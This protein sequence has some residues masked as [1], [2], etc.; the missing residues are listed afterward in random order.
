MRPPCSAC[1]FERA[2]GVIVSTHSD[3][4]KTAPPSPAQRRRPHGHK[5]TVDPTTP[6]TSTQRSDRWGDI[7]GDLTQ[8]SDRCSQSSFGDQTTVGALWWAPR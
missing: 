1:L 6:T 7:T 4:P 8:R 5:L 3:I 2:F